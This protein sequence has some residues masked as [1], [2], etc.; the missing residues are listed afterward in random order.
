MPIDDEVLS[1]LEVRGVIT[2][3]L[4]FRFSKARDVA[5]GRAEQSEPPYTLCPA[6]CGHYLVAKHASYTDSTLYDRPLGALMTESKGVRLGQCPCGALV[7]PHCHKLI[8]AAD[9]SVHW[10]AEADALLS[11]DKLQHNIDAAKKLVRPDGHTKEEAKMLRKFGKECPAC[12]SF[13]QKAEGCHIMQCGGMGAHKDMNTCLRAGGCGHEFDW[14]TMAP[15]RFGKP[16]EPAN[17]RQVRFRRHGQNYNV[18]RT[19]LGPGAVV[20]LHCKAHNRYLRLTNDAVLGSPAKAF[21]KLPATWMDDRFIVVGCAFSTVALWSPMHERF[22][23]ANGQAVD[24]K[25]GVKGVDKLPWHWRKERFTAVDVGGGEL[26]LHSEESGSFVAM[27]ADGRVHAG[28]P[29]A[30]WDKLTDAQ[31]ADAR[32]RFRPLVIA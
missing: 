15:M 13:I 14:N 17:D 3:E 2:R 22:V 21:N 9:E 19:M 30:A 12:G 1:F 4:V 20:A 32:I 18:S 28:G 11:A 16:G 25:G 23:R 10:C 26:A 6:A 29:R 7:C 24:A 27:E 5:A 31:K 8:A